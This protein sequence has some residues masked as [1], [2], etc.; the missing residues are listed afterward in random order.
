[1]EC[2]CNKKE[3]KQTLFIHTSYFD[4]EKDVDFKNDLI[5][6]QISS[7]TGSQSIMLNKKELIKELISLSN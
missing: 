3:C 2:K 4:G 6:L 7:Y 1:M 5:E